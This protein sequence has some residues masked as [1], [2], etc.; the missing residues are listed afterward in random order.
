MIFLPDTEQ[1]KNSYGISKDTEEILR[2]RNKVD[3]KSK[4]K[5]IVTKTTWY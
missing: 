5:V 1:S 4:Y 2:K 3:F